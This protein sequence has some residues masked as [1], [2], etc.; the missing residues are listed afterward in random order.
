MR[1]S[2]LILTLLLSTPAMAAGPADRPPDLKPVPGGVPGPDDAPPVTI[3]E[4]KQGS[5]IEYRANG[6][7]YML[8]VIPRVGKPYYLMDRN[9]DGAFARHEGPGSGLTPPMWVVKEF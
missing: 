1:P 7:L 9:G 3:K 2:L 4:S 8:K 6:K 5:V